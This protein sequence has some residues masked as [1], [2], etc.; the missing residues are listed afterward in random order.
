MTTAILIIAAACL[1]LM[2]AIGVGVLKIIGMLAAIIYGI[3][4]NI[5]FTDVCYSHLN[6][7]NSALKLV[8]DD[9]E[10]KTTKRFQTAVDKDDFQMASYYKALIE[11]ITKLKTMTNEDI[12]SKDN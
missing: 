5:G 9:I 7:T 2:V 1:L 3:Q 6:F 11:A 12:E 8:L 10:T 4:E